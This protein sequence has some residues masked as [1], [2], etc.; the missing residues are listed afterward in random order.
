MATVTLGA[1]AFGQAG[2]PNP[3]PY[4]EAAAFPRVVQITT[5]VN[6]TQGESAAASAMFSPLRQARQQVPQL[7]LP[8]ADG[9]PV[10]TS[11]DRIQATAGIT[12]KVKLQ[13]DLSSGARHRAE[14]TR[15]MIADQASS[16]R[17]QSA[18][19]NVIG[20]STAA[21]PAPLPR[22]ATLRQ[23]STDIVTKKVPPPGLQAAV[24][25]S[26]AGT[27]DRRTDPAP[28]PRGSKSSIE[29]PFAAYTTVESQPRIS[30]HEDSDAADLL[31]SSRRRLITSSQAEASDDAPEYLSNAQT[32]IFAAAAVATALVLPG[33]VSE[34]RRRRNRTLPQFARE[35]PPPLQ[36]P[37][38]L[39]EQAAAKYPIR[40]KAG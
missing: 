6:I 16:S 20:Q 24:S 37:E 33:I 30:R 40:E 36:S 34:I 9:R 27:N 7:V 13:S 18:D 19:A 11:I 4:F 17:A 2:D 14:L 26:G 39:S 29:N 15:P 32:V 25:S 23:S 22:E 28:S 38:R 12:T 1:G 10:A 5:E 21:A 31:Y 8:G 35:T 3:L